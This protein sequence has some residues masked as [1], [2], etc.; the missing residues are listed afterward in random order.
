MA[1]AVKARFEQSIKANRD[2]VIHDETRNDNA[3]VTVVRTGGADAK[4]VI[5][6]VKG[7]GDDEKTEVA[8]LN[9]LG[10]LVEREVETFPPATKSGRELRHYYIEQPIAPG[11]MLSEY[12]SNPIDDVNKAISC[13]RNLCIELQRL[14]SIAAHC[15]LKLDNI[16]FDGETGTTTI[17]D[18]GK[19]CQWEYGEDETRNC[20]QHEMGNVPSH[21][22]CCEERI[23]AIQ[24]RIIFCDNPD[25]AFQLARERDVIQ[26]SLA[27]HA[28]GNAIDWKVRGKFQAVSIPLCKMLLSDVEDN[29]KYV[30]RQVV[31]KTTDANGGIIYIRTDMFLD[32]RYQRVEHARHRIN[33]QFGDEWQLKDDQRILNDDNDIP[34]MLYLVPDNGDAVGDNDSDSDENDPPSHLK[35][36]ESGHGLL[37]SILS[38]LG[39]GSR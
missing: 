1:T 32:Q 17:I 38:R 10:R 36:T 24:R 28:L 18:F 31:T 35:D 33:L 14:H 29:V 11:V 39:L 22:K 25:E 37:R 26:F 4:T 6:R 15:D 5:K 12:I 9:K 2:N 13:A 16:M 27:C 7:G 23:N 3:G 19:A 30:K 20:T 8:I 21:P 34:K